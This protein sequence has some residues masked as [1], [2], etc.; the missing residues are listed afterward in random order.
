[1]KTCK[2]CKYFNGENWCC[3]HKFSVGP[4][5]VACSFMKTPRG[6]EEI[7]EEE[8]IPMAEDTPGGLYVKY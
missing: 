8:E 3:L 7:L 6:N 4:D 1:M 5:D 2:D